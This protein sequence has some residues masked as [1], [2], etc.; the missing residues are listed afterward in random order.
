MNGLIQ[1]V[2]ELVPSKH[3]TNRTERN[4]RLAS[5]ASDAEM[6]TSPVAS[7]SEPSKRLLTSEEDK[8][9][10]KLPKMD[11]KPGTE[12]RYT[13]IPMDK[14]PK[15]SNPAEITKHSMDGS[16]QLEAYLTHFK[17]HDEVLAELQFAFICFLAGQHYESFE[18]WKQLLTLFCSCDDA[19]E[20]HADFFISLITDLH[21]QIRE[22]PD[23]FFIDILSCNNFLIA[24]LSRLFAMINTNE[25]VSPRLKSHAGKFKANLSKKFDWE[26]D[27]EHE[28]EEDAPVVVELDDAS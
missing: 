12:I 28:C 13:I 14:Y 15:G 25:S 3:R 2:T 20:T 19:L 22:V 24:I 6:S 18:R 16:F 27:D 4:E 9:K 8:D 5:G 1:S 10:D 26:F 21:F 7:T 11:L 17:R 23:D